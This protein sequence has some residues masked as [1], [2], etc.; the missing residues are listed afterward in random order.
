MLTPVVHDC[1]WSGEADATVE[2]QFLPRWLLCACGNHD[3]ACTSAQLGCIV[4]QPA[5]PLAM[6]M[7]RLRLFTLDPEAQACASSSSCC[8][9]CGWAPTMALASLAPG[10][11]AS[12]SGLPVGPAAG[13]HSV[14]DLLIVPGALSAI[15]LS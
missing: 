5:L 8:V 10:P 14:L 11:P 13:R 6:R 9:S 2:D 15:W 3:M 4:A 12:F 1:F 7:R